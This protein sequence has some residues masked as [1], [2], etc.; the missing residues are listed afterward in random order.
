M[1]LSS[2]IISENELIS[3]AMEMIQINDSRCVMVV[4]KESKVVGILS[5]G[6]ILRA[7]MS[8][9]HVTAHVKTIVN[10][11]FKYLY[12]FDVG[13]I[14]QMLKEGI[15]LVP[16]LNDDN[17]LKEVVTLKSFYGNDQ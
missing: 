10:P 6:D 9:V 7:I 17:T 11:S 8:G 2:Y 14:D 16:I 12:V 5:E 4:N 13:Q 3:V 15:T 1:D